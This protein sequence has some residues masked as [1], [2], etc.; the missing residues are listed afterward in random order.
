MPTPAA[1]P[2]RS[3]PAAPSPPLER[4]AT[5]DSPSHRDSSPVEFLV[6]TAPQP[7]AI[8]VIELH[9]A[10]ASILESLAPPERWHDNRLLY[11]DFWAIDRGLAARTG[12]KSAILMPH[13][14]PRVMQR[15]AMK[16]REL[17]AMPLVSPYYRES[18]PSPPFPEAA[19][20]LVIQSVL[21]TLPLA[22]SP[23]AID[24]LLDQPRR[25]NAD[26]GRPLGDDDLARSARLNRLLDPP[27]VVL[28]GPANVGKSTLSNALIGRSMSIALDLPGT[29]RDATAGLIDLG[30]LVVRWY[31]TPGLRPSDDPIEQAAIASAERLI[32]EA[33][34][35]I[36]ATDHEHGW[37]KLPRPAD[38]HVRTKADLAA[39]DDDSARGALSQ[40][41]SPP[42]DLALSAAT[43]EN[44]P[45]FIALVRDRLLP[46]AD[47]AH[48]G[49]WLFHPRL[50]ARA[51]DSRCG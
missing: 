19:S 17:G 14:G 2:A 35:L 9:G 46:P 15:L 3:S 8:G 32:N 43:G 42:P 20:N 26:A 10:V 40:H 6:S 28:A 30:G 4:H 13:G 47:L 49:R 31:D 11:I 24:L 21:E 1:D 51:G 33:E 27:V 16:L 41:L 38:L 45:A 48:P 7:G 22:R 39:G 37:P 36:A 44:L 5:L 25:W 12:E 34:L 29:T 50:A 18:E 23:L